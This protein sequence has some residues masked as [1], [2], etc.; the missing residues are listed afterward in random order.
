VN[1]RALFISD[2][3]ICADDIPQ[4]PIIDVVGSRRVPPTE[5]IFSIFMM[6][7]PFPSVYTSTEQS[8]NNDSSNS[9]VL[10]V[11]AISAACLFA[12]LVSISAVVLIVYVYERKSHQSKLPYGLVANQA[13]RS[14]ES[15]VEGRKLIHKESRV[16]E[17]RRLN[18]ES[19]QTAVSPNIQSGRSTDSCSSGDSAFVDE[20]AVTTNDISGGKFGWFLQVSDS[21][22]LETCGFHS[23]ICLFKL[24]LLGVF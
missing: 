20:A 12:G 5:Q 4:Q 10:S 2:N 3:K 7:S 21:L 9:S 19:S 13:I 22:G 1:Y 6:S 16:E 8:I 24:N 17:K 11:I 15:N 14:N 18:S 23:T